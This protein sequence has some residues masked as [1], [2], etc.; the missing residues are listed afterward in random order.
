MGLGRHNFGGT[1]MTRVVVGGHCGIGLVSFEKGLGGGEGVDGRN[2][3]VAVGKGEWL[4]VGVWA[5]GHRVGSTKRR[6]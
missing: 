2:A 6:K 1:S 5:S 3:V 4:N